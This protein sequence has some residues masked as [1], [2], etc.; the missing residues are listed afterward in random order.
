MTDT[1]LKLI[2]ADEVSVNR[3]SLILNT[4]RKDPTHTRDEALRRVEGHRDDGCASV[5]AGA[6][7]CDGVD[8]I[9]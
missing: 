5:V 1:E 7:G 4:L 6:H 2:A 3:P 8:R 9:L